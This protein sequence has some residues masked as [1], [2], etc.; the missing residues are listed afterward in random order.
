M[1][2]GFKNLRSLKDTGF[3]EI[4]SLT[5]L[6]GQNSSGKSTF[7]RA[8]PLLRQSVETKTKGPILWYGSYVDFGDF[9][10]ALWDK[11]ED[12]TIEFSF[13]F[14]LP[15]ERGSRL[16]YTGTNSLSNKMRK[17]RKIQFFIKLN[18]D[19]NNSTYASELKIIINDFEI[20]VKIDQN[21]NVEI[22]VDNHKVKA[23][24]IKAYNGMNGF[25]PQIL[26]ITKDRMYL[27]NYNHLTKEVHQ[28]IRDISKME[29]ADETIARIIS[30]FNFDSNET[31][32]N[33]VK[34]SDAATKFSKNVKDLN[35]DSLVFKELKGIMLASSIAYF[36]SIIDQYLSDMFKAVSYIAPL[37]ATADRY[38]RPQELS[39][40]EVDFQ[41]KN[42]A[43]VLAN[44]SDGEKNRFKEWCLNNFDFY[45][46]AT[47]NGGNISIYVNFKQDNSTTNLKHNIIDLGFGFSQIL[48]IITQIWNS[49]ENNNSRQKKITKIFVIEQPELHLHPKLQTK[50]IDALINV[51]SFCK[52]KEMD[53][54]FIIE[55]HSETIINTVGNRIYS[56]KITA[57][58]VNILLFERK[59]SFTDII[60]AGFSNEGLLVNW[61]YGFFEEF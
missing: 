60:Q 35:I 9:K 53:F 20:I 52:S 10:T 59:D 48:P 61:P 13:D 14:E 25:I 54:K 4:R 47:L 39:I 38:Y 42:L 17:Y 1:K 40:D 21:Q 22:F 12:K 28:I 31:L 15:P 24:N 50:F 45:P 29:Y 3:H 51:L 19:K 18:S 56:Q 43:L 49:V 37:R 23:E 26:S 32:F 11:T 27:G 33:S 57:D 2:I 34:N 55:T 30:T 16:Y 8:F 5:F 58:N 44:F 46:E 36:V 6:L 41:G 7:L